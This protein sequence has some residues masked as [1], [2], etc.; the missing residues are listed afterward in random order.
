[1]SGVK[2]VSFFTPENDKNMTCFGYRARARDSRV[3]VKCL[4]LRANQSF[5]LRKVKFSEPSQE[6]NTKGENVEFNTMEIE[7]TISAL[8]NGDWSEAKE[9]ATKADAIAHIEGLLGTISG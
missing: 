4:F 9:F 3:R 5:C 6:D 7:G 1:M 2:A 8:A